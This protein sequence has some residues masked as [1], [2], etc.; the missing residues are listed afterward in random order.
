MTTGRKILV[1]GAVAIAVIVAGGVWFVRARNAPPP[2]EPPPVAS[3]D[4]RRALPQ[5]ELSGFVGRYGSHV[6]LGIPYAQP[7]VGPLRWKAPRPPEPWSGV[8]EA[9]AAGSPCTQITG[10]LGE[11]PGV[12]RGSEDCLYLNVWAPRFAP[13]EVPAAAE[14]LPVMVW[15]HGGSN[16]FGNGAQYDGGNLAARHRVIVVSMNYRL[17]PLGWFIHPALRAQAETPEDASGN[18]GTLD[19]VRALGWVRENI[20]RFGGDPANVTV[21]GES[22]GGFNIVNLLIS[23]LTE[24]MFQR[25]IVQ[26]GGLGTRTLAEAENFRDDATPGARASSSEILLRLRTADG[27]ASDAQQARTQLAAMSASEIAEYLRAKSGADFLRA[28]QNQPTDWSYSFP[29]SFADGRVIR[30]GDILELL[31]NPATYNDVP[32]IFG[33]NRDELKLFFMGDPEVVRADW[34]GVPRLRI[35]ADAYQARAQYG[36]QIWKLNGADLPAARMRGAQ[37]PSVYVYR[38]DWDEEPS[39]LGSDLGVL[40][41]AAHGFEIPFAFGHFPPGAR[42]IFGDPEQASIRELSTAMMSY[43]AEFA[44]SGAPGQGRD[45]SLPAWTAWESAEGA[46]RSIV[47][48]TAAGGGVRM[49]SE[50]L[51]WESVIA[52]IRSDTRLDDAARCSL[53]QDAR[54]APAELYAAIPCPAPVAATP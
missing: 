43:W 12:L 53:M 48:D 7:P 1:T 47:F 14:R 25:A 11:A 6:W 49:S 13:E 31:S 34:I 22:A 21:F 50:T 3:A 2:P 5:G 40:L 33:T 28:Y 15:V 38:F 27:S 19:L 29:N 45:G 24:G 46:P 54:G 37:G 8:R 41:G 23:P 39:V 10:P 18:W 32:A 20:E 36:S 9:L 17:G 35:D 44:Y 26:S 4:A 51:S 16:L 30:A 52:G 42:R